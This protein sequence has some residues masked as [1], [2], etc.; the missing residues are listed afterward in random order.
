MP[1][2]EPKEKQRNRF[3]EILA[4]VVLIGGIVWL[5][6]LFFDF[7]GSERTNNAQVDANIIDV[8]SRVAG[9]I[10][11]VRFNAYSPVHA[12]DTLVIIDDAEY[13][14]KVAQS[15][16]DLEMAKANLKAMEQAV[17]TSQANQEASS[18]K[19]KGNEANLERAEKNYKRFENMYADSAV[20]RNQFDQVI[21]QLK[22]DQAF[23]EASQKDILADKST[24][25]QNKVNVESSKATVKRKTAD[26][27]AA[28]L[29][30]SYTIITAPVDGVIGERTIETGALVGA[31]QVLASIVQQNKM[32]VTAN[33]KE[34]QVD[35]IK[36]GQ[37]VVIEVDALGGKKLE[38]VVKDFSP[39]TGAKFSMVEPDN[40]TGNFVKITQRIPIRIEFTSPKEDLAA[41]RPGMNVTVELK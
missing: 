14:I 5:A 39:A 20:T 30:L 40:S 16:A 1:P 29:Q 22:S 8:T 17:I 6:W 11:E 2:E 28:R 35:D 19:L 33:F 18:S 31:N 38:G 34:T 10:K 36:I 41:I 23:L 7:G 21:A 25:E 32:W 26:L 13:R 3:V 9:N 37:K 27:D 15:E 24:T 4:L 12:G